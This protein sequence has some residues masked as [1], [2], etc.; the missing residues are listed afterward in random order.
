MQQSLRGSLLSP[1][2]TSGT[3]FP[4]DLGICQKSFNICIYLCAQERE[5]LSL[6]FFLLLNLLCRYNP[7]RP[8]KQPFLHC[9]PLSRANSGQAECFT[10]SAG[11]GLP[12]SSSI[13]VPVAL[14]GC[15]RRRYG[16]SITTPMNQH[17]RLAP[18][19]H[20]ATLLPPHLSI[21]SLRLH[22]HPCLA[23]DG[24]V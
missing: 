20:C 23:L 14:K 4:N 13:A 18:L 11:P 5:A 24:K 16:K 21:V 10:L 3:L 12:E 7:F 8:H 22:I 2:T 6:S 1:F 9:S 17:S 15:H 19:G